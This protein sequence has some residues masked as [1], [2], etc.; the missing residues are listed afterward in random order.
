MLR[1]VT[2][3]I[4]VD[5]VG[6]ALAALLQAFTLREQVRA[7]QRAG[8]LE[9]PSLGADLVPGTEVV[10]VGEALIAVTTLTRKPQ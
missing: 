2:E 10:S 6:V 4:W 7:R 8:Q 1:G 9:K 3:L 5:G